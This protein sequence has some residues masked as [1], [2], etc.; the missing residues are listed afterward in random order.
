[1]TDKQTTIVAI[2]IT[3]VCLIM[4]A[5]LVGGCHQIEQTHRE[6]IKAGYVQKIDPLTRSTIWV[7]PD[8]E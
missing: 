5:G 8:K 2:T 3:L 6:Y 4:T 1:M 7:R